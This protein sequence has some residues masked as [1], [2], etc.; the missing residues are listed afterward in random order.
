M[1]EIQKEIHHTPFLK[2]TVGQI[3]KIMGFNERVKNFLDDCGPAS[4]LMMP[5]NYK[6]TEHDPD[7]IGHG[8]LDDGTAIRLEGVSTLSK[9]GNK[10]LQLKIVRIPNDIYDNKMFNVTMDYKNKPNTGFLD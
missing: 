7:F 3:L 8:R 4:A 2:R 6:K 9:K 10:L 1:T 5:N